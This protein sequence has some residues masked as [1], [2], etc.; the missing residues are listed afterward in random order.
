MSN[1]GGK[2]LNNKWIMGDLLGKGACCTGVYSCTPV[3]KS[4]KESSI[5]WACKVVPIDHITLSSTI[6]KTKKKKTVI[7]RLA[8]TI[9]YE[10]TLYN[11]H[12]ISLRDTKQIPEIPSN[13]IR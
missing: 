5:K 13:G 9:F 12:L 1:L 10:Y 11:A 6:L 7:E 3:K 8:D 4:S 2:T